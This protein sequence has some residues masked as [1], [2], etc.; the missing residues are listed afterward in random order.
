MPY[1]HVYALPRPSEMKAKAMTR[2]TEV[3]A[4]E[5]GIAADQIHFIWHDMPAENIAK[6]GV[7]MAEIK[8]A[9]G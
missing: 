2:M 9:K 8:K 7:T 6:A 3:M 1:L 5:L 4:E